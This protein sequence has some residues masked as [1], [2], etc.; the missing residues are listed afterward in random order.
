MAFTCTCAPG[1]TLH[2]VKSGEGMFEDAPFQGRDA[3]EPLQ[4]QERPR[5]SLHGQ[6]P[7][8]RVFGRSGE[9]ETTRRLGSM[10]ADG[11]ARAPAAPVP[12]RSGRGWPRSCFPFISGCSP[13]L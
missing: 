10:K 11:P 8:L 1:G 9:H 12:V 4:F 5:L 2:L 13:A 6:H 3:L 7:L